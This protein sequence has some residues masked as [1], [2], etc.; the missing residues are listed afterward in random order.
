MSCLLNITQR[1]VVLCATI[2]IL[3]ACG[4]KPPEKKPRPESV[5][6]EGD[7]SANS[8]SKTK[9]NGDTSS[10]SNSNG[11]S[12]S[13]SN[14]KT[15]DRSPPS[16]TSFVSPFALV[17]A[18]EIRQGN[19]GAKF[20]QSF[21]ELC[22]G[23]SKPNALLTQTLRSHAYDGSGTPPLFRLHEPTHDAVLQTTELVAAASIKIPVK[24]KVYA[25]KSLGCNCSP[26]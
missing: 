5:D 8:E 4:E 23:D 7:T 25:E 10:K 26:N 16:T 9:A 2:C 22:A 19:V 13:N 12:S 3:G 15:S 21:A 6:K 20:S 11:N 24:A 1:A 14:Q 17:C 18:P